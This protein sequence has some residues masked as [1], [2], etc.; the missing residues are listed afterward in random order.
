[1]TGLHDPDAFRV[2]ECVLQYL[3]EHADAGDTVEG[4]LTWWLDGA[5]SP[6]PAA[7]RRAMEWLVVQGCVERQTLPDGTVVYRNVRG[8]RPVT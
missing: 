4:I 7:V 8:P 5:P 2:A 1:M 3:R 6:T